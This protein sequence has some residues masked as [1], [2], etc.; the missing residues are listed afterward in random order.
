[1]REGEAYIFSSC[2][3]DSCLFLKS[4]LDKNIEILKKT[5][6]SEGKKLP[7]L[8]E[9]ELSKKNGVFNDRRYKLMSNKG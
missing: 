8:S 4:G 7:L 1:M 5:L 6:E 2:F 9:H 3:Q